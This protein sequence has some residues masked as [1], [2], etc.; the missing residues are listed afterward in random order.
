L[1][2][3]L[4]RPVR[5][6]GLPDEEFGEQATAAVVLDAPALTEEDAKDFSRDELVSYKK[7]RRVAFVDAARNALSEVL[8]HEVG[9][10]LIDRMSR[11]KR[12]WVQKSARLRTRGKEQSWRVSADNKRAIRNRSGR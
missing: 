3:G 6:D 7:P 10:E 8:K 9:E 2:N 5:Q 11:R 12:Y 4:R 1:V